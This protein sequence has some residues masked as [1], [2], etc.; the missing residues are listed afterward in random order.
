MRVHVVI[1]FDPNPTTETLGQSDQW[2]HRISACTVILACPDEAR[3]VVGAQFM[4]GLLDANLCKN[5]QTNNNKPFK[6]LFI[7]CFCLFFA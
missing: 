1:L 2:L 5:K 7:V 3:F 6:M 4:S